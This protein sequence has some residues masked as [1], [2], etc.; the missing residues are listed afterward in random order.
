VTKQTT[1]VAGISIVLLVVLA[2]RHLWPGD[3]QPPPLVPPS[4]SQGDGGGTP[5]SPGA[6][7]GNAGQTGGGH[8]AEITYPK[9]LAISQKPKPENLPVLKK[10]LKSPSWRNRHIAA[11]TVGRLGRKGDPPSLL[12]V[13]RNKQEKPAVR[14]AAAE[15]LG[16]MKHVEAGPDLIDAMSDPSEIVRAASGVAISKIMGMRFEY[17]A[18]DP[19]YKRERAIAL[20]RKF[21]PEFHQASKRM[22]ERGG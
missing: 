9:L 3:D 10:A 7:V 5:S 1:V 12:E 22:P 16:A 13:L 21:W 17:Y 18:S 20:A 8:E 6:P 2:V 4:A 14:A 15:A 19:A 11:V